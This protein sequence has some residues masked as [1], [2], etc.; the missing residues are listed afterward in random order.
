MAIAQRAPQ[1]VATNAHCGQVLTASLTLN[2][3][4]FCT[5]GTGLTITGKGVVLNLAGHQIDGAGTASAGV[6]VQGNSDIVENGV[7]SRFSNWGV[8]VDGIDS[9]PT[10]TTLSAVRAIGNFTGIS[11]GGM[12][13]KITNSTTTGNT[14][15]IEGYGSGGTY[16]GDHELN[17]NIDGLV[18]EGATSVANSN[19][20]DGNGNYGIWD[21]LDAG[22][23]LTR[24]TADFNGNDGIFIQDA[25][26]AVDGGG[27]L[28]KGN[29]YSAG[30]PPEQCR[31]VVCG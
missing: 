18:V 1:V 30:N 2:G 29:D 22:S 21:V 8:N 13:S 14:Y 6:L 10:S 17:N 24:N 11:D 26:T 20:A 12:N 16:S 19:V 7:L 9:M 5:S 28:A 3:D 31:G 25:P 27:N 4:L 23:T 15:G